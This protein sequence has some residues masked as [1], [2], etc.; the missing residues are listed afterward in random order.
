MGSLASK[1]SKMTVSK[2][3]NA[4]EIREFIKQAI[5][6]EKVV[7]FSK[8]YCPY[9]KLAKDVYELDEREDES[10]FQDNLAILNGFRSV[11]QVYINGKCI[12]GGTDVKNLYET[13]KL[14]PMLIG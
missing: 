7:I 10:D 6:E 12:G 13:G 9:C 1:S 2:M 8:T 14:E 3:A 11:P 4:Q 5:T